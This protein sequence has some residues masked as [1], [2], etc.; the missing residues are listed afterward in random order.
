[1]L[2]NSHVFLFLFLPVALLV[3]HLLGRGGRAR[4]AAL[5]L[6]A[7][8]LFF[9]GWWDPRYLPLLVG[10]VVLNYGLGRWLGT[11]TASSRLR[12]AVLAAG[13]AVDLGALGW[14]KYAHF[15]AANLSFL[16]G[17]DLA[18]PPIVLPLAISFFT[19]Q[20]IAFL[21]DRW[22]RPGPPP[23][24][25]EYALFVT[26]FPQL[27]A[28]PIVHHTETIPQFARP[29][30]YR[31]RRADLEVGATIFF[32]GLAKKVL[33]ADGVA[34]YATRVFEQVALGAEP[35]AFAAWT[36]A[37][38]YTFQLYFDFSGYSDMAI[39]LARMFGVRLPLNF[40]APYKA[41]SI[42]EFWRRWHMTLSRFLRDHLYVPLGGNRRGTA[43]RH[44]NIMITM[45]LG[46]LWHGA[47]WTF[48][49]WG[50]L[51]G[52]F[53]LVNHAWRA[54][55]GAGRE[56]RAAWLGGWP[57]RF[58]TFGVVVVAWVFFRAASLDDAFTLLGGMAGLRGAVW[59][60]AGAIR[61]VHLALLWAIVWWAPTTQAIMAGAEPALG[62]RR[63]RG[64]APAWLA[65]RP[66]P[67]FAVAV[68][69]VTLF[70]V[71]GI[72]RYSEFLYFQF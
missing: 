22:R 38:A 1:M 53:L 25:L 67:A 60:D 11:A 19:F 20:Q 6:V 65:W 39:G 24:W 5:W 70:G 32:L 45:L 57:A 15:T 13:I 72:N 30:L 28:G 55:R 12:G 54:L 27:I 44:V 3:F 63:A 49:V 66:S 4:G 16:A 41:T 8:S 9:Y 26:F 64:D 35:E 17:V 21:V 51:H 34:P 10:S 69:V 7:A 36:A 59:P 58:A 61:V 33:L 68:G 52:A 71:L 29:S 56:A 37:L 48:V 31:L 62:Y 23:G 50:G 2:F 47:A 18:L 14:F 40:D 46:G 43:R 42:V